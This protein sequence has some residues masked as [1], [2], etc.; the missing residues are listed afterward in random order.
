MLGLPI[1]YLIGEQ[2]DIKTFI[3]SDLKPN[4]K[5]RLKETV[6]NVSLEYQLAGE[7][8]P[9]L[10][11]DDYDCQAI[12]FFDIKLNSIKNAS[13]V[14]EIIQ[15]LGKPLY[16]IKMY[17]HTGVEVYH[18][19]HKR[20]SIQDRS[21]V[22]VLDMVITSPTSQEFED[23]INVLMEEYTAF[24]KIKNR[25]NKLSFYLEMMVKSYIISD[26]SLWSRSKS[27]LDNKVWYNADDV[28]RLFEKLKRVEQLKREQRSVKTISATSKI[29]SEL[30][31]IYTGLE[32]IIGKA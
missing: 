13:F 31:M 4:E 17:D 6:M 16:V 10:I 11:N 9:S 12:L 23:E 29:N 15:K 1:Q 24:S 21:Q 5:K 8:I 20:L 26:T 19:A 30:K 7:E 22:V 25:T 28:I 2:I 32:K 14:G 27:L 3:T 18:F